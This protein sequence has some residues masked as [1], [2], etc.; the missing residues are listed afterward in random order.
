MRSK[1]IPQVLLLK[2]YKDRLFGKAYDDGHRDILRSILSLCAG[3]EC[4]KGD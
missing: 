3:E 2:E 1:K 4:Y